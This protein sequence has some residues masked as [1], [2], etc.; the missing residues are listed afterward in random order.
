MLKN[1][2]KRK[3]SVVFVWLLSYA[4]ILLVPILFSVFI[5][6]QASR[7]LENE[8]NQSNNFLLKRVQQYMDSL[9]VDVESLSHEI[10][11][12]S[13]LQ[14]LLQHR[15]ALTDAQQYI[16]YQTVQNFKLYKISNTSIDR[17]FVY[18]KDYDLVISDSTSTDSR[19][20]FESYYAQGRVA[21]WEWFDFIKQNYSGEYKSQ[22]W[23]Q[24]NG[25]YTVGIPSAGDKTGGGN[26]GGN[27]I[28]FSRSIPTISKD[29][30][31]A[32]M[33]IPVDE[34]RFLR[35]AEGIEF[36]SGGNVFIINGRNE[37]IA[38]TSPLKDTCIIEYEALQD[39]NGLC[40]AEFS[41]ERIA[42]SYIKSTINDW[43]YVSV[44]PV[45]VHDY[46]RA[47]ILRLHKKKLQA[48]E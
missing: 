46:C 39:E 8:I 18:F 28:V 10:M 9:L 12:N 23:F 44:I 47:D 45:A 1:V 22:P 27:V 19:T 41:G 36:T 17:F 31:S 3:R 32:N 34:S 26:T 21:Y 43:K 40:Y 37:I 6:T 11:F 30:I 48:S 20:Y 38:S 4:I 7:L 16:V 29:A 13:N 15:G 24:S 25:G 35:D 14:A 42:V 5:Y 33:F 2:L